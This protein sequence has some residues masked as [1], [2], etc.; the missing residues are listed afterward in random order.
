MNKKRG[1]TA[2]AILLVC[3]VVA[4]GSL[5]AYVKLSE[6]NPVAFVEKDGLLV[7]QNDHYEAAFYAD[8]GG[9]DMLTVQ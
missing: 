2:A 9:L 4:G 8:R 1:W 7:V 6:K 3:L 5:F